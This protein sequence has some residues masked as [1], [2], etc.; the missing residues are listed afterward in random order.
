MK[1]QNEAPLGE[2]NV[3]P[4]LFSSGPHPFK[5]IHRLST[6]FSR[7]VL[8]DAGH[9]VELSAATPKFRGTWFGPL[10]QFTL[11]QDSP[12]PN[13]QAGPTPGKF[14]LVTCCQPNR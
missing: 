14:V 12:G 10:P 3:C 13:S 6:S 8:G 1:F 7:L 5:T 4:F 11:T 2:A 9:R